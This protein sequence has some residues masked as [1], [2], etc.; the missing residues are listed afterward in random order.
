MCWIIFK[1]MS[2][3]EGEVKIRRLSREL[4]WN[5]LATLWTIERGWLDPV[6]ILVKIST[7]L[8]NLYRNVSE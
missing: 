1:I 5:G 4:K 8:S 7:S 3:F 6:A 2:L